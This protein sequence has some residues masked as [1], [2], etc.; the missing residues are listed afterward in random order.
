MESF[1]QDQIKQKVISVYCSV[2]PGGLPPSTEGRGELDSMA[3]L[4]FISGLE[5]EFDI[6]IDVQDI[7][8]ENFKTTA[9]TVALVQKKIDG[10]K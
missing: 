2:S 6:V 7:S 3:F 9:S 8:D 5:S 1:T 10:I 4:E